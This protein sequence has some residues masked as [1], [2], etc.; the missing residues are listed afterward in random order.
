MSGVAAIALEKWCALRQCSCLTS[1]QNDSSGKATETT[2]GTN[3]Q[4][5]FV[6]TYCVCVCALH[7][8]SV[9]VCVCVC[10]RACVRACVHAC[11]HPFMHVCGWLPCPLL[12]MVCVYLFHV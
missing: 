10:V 1:G 11:M 2:P 6:C 5:R 12:Q 4:A 8:H 7:A 9:H 3:Y